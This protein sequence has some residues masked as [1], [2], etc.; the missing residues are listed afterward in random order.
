[1]TIEEGEIVLL[2]EKDSRFRDLILFALT[3][4]LPMFNEP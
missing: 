1:L 4:N 3:K 2:Y